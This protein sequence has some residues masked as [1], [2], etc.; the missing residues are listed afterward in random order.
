MYPSFDLYI[1]LSIC[2][3]IY[4][5]KHAGIDNDGD[6]AEVGQ[7]S[8]LKKKQKTSVTTWSP[9]VSVC[10]F[11]HP[12]IY[13]VNPFDNK[14]LEV[15]SLRRTGHLQP[16]LH[17]LIRCAHVHITGSTSTSGDRCRE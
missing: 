8:S 13:R 5:G 3:S 2:L 14:K 15:K 11:M 17:R 1:Y 4:L 10:L 6:K 12:P 9:V 7:L 16:E